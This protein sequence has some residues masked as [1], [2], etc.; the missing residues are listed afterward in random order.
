LL[1]LTGSDSNFYL[2]PVNSLFLFV[3]TFETAMKNDGGRGGG[4]GGVGEESVNTMEK[5]RRMVHAHPTL[6][7]VRK[8]ECTD[9]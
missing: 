5:K 7:P 6:L 1:L 9:E 8:K 2:A 4:V 3:C